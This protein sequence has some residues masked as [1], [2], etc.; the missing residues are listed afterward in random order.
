[1]PYALTLKALT[2]NET[3]LRIPS[4]SPRD[5][6]AL[7]NFSFLQTFRLPDTNW[8]GT[9][10]VVGISSLRNLT[11]LDIGSSCLKRPRV[12]KG[13]ASHSQRIPSFYR[14]RAAA[15]EASPLS[16][17][18]SQFTGLIKL[19]TFFPNPGSVLSRFTRL[20][21][22]RMSVCESTVADL[23]HSLP[24]LELL[25]ELDLLSYVNIS[26]RGFSRLTKLKRLSL[27][28]PKEIDEEF[29]R[30]LPGLS[31]LTSL[32]VCHPSE[33]SPSL[34]YFAQFNHLSSLRE[35]HIASVSDVLLNPCDIFQ[36]G[37][38]PRLRVLGV[39]Y[40]S[41]SEDIHTTMMKRFP[42]INTLRS[43]FRGWD[44]AD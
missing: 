9:D 1:M 20:T 11:E 13:S 42:S 21:T 29:F 41:F 28:I 33:T 27:S 38:L 3:G 14:F 12:T 22:L 10:C 26:A 4:I 7:S 16:D 37:C 32:I 39:G 44:E 8:I 30:V 23:E 6:M 40:G 31:Q 25:E 36:E 18:I 2:I 15:I 17:S 34:S 24:S 35:L 5:R 43:G 19:S